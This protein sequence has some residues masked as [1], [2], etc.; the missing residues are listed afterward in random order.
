MRKLKVYGGNIDGIRR[1]ILAF[2]TK[3]EAIKILK[4]SMY[5]FNLYW[6]ETGNDEEIKIAISKPGVVFVTEIEYGKGGYKE[7]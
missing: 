5:E 2:E 1:G 3:K 4:M 6:G 7:L